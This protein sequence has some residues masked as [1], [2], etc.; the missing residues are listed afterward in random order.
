MK[1]S[2]LY[3]Y[4]VFI[5]LIIFLM[6]RPISQLFLYY[7]EIRYQFVDVVEMH[8]VWIV[9][10]IM[11]LILTLILYVYKRPLFLIREKSKKNERR[12]WLAIL[13]FLA[14]LSIFWI[15]PFELINAKLDNGKFSY[16]DEVVV[17]KILR[18]SAKSLSTYELETK[19]WR[20]NRDVEFFQV[21]ETFYNSII[22]TLSRVR[23]CTKPGALGY[24]WIC[25][26]RKLD[27]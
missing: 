26:I 23:I 19:S 17:S 11:G 12:K 25:G 21:D 9:G 8:N 18:S 13:T 20:K 14:I 5:I 7:S 27:P 3:R 16:H 2:F 15:Y 22:P 6:L 1:A 4:R 10:I 24:E